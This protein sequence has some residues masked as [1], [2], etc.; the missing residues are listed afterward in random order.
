MDKKWK[1]VVVAVA[2]GV[3]L[4]Q[5]LLSAV[6]Q[7][8]LSE[9][10]ETLTPTQQETQL[11]PSARSTYLPVLTAE[12][13]I[14]VMELEAYVLGVVLAEMPAEF[15]MEALK[16]Q[17]VVARTYALRRLSRQDRHADVAVCADPNCCQ[18]YMTEEEFLQKGETVSGLE[19]IARA[20]EA[21]KGQVLIY[22]GALIEATY[23]SCS[24]GRTEDAVAVWGEVIPYL[25]AVD[26]PGEENAEKYWEEVHFTA[27][28]FEDALGRDLSGT[29]RSWLGK[30]TFTAGGGVQTMVIGGI[31]YTGTQLRQLLGLNSTAFTMAAEDGGITVETLGK[32]HRVGMSQYGADAMARGGSSYDEI[33]MHY[34]PG[35]RID[36]TENIL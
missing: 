34:Y 3:I 28:E 36:K 18:A 25:Q 32:G 12:N 33:L 8:P 10:A 27:E 16:A 5:L 1:P 7:R 11:S 20:V 35:T 6:R 23:F 13:S 9:P 26:S 19:K 15:E 14:H 4:P 17:A 21:T 22:G 29:P 30:R 24:G 31:A 2:L